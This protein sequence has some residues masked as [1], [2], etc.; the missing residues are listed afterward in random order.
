M[1]QQSNNRFFQTALLLT[2]LALK[3]NI[4]EAQSPQGFKYQGVARNAAS[5][6]I[7]NQNIAIRLSI[8]LDPDGDGDGPLV[9]RERHQTITSDLGVFSLN[10]G[11]GTALSGTFANIVWG[12]NLHAMRTELDP[13]GGNTFTFM[14]S[15]PILSVPYALHAQT[16]ASAPQADPS[17]SNELQ[18]LALNGTQLSISQGNT[19]DLSGIG[20]GGS[21]PWLTNGTN[22]Y[23]DNGSVGIGTN[24]PARHLEIRGTD[25]RFLR[26]LATNPGSSETGI[27]L[28]RGNTAG[29]DWRISNDGGELGFT[30]GSDNFLTEANRHMTLTAVGNLGL[31]TDAPAR[32]F[33][34]REPQTPTLRLHA[35]DGTGTTEAGIEF[36]RGNTAGTDWKMVNDGG[37]LRVKTGADNFATEGETVAEFT[38]NGNLNL[39]G[40]E[41]KNIAAPVAGTDAV[42]RNWVEAQIST[43]A[44]ATLMS[45]NNYAQNQAAMAETDANS[46]TQS[47]VQQYFED[48]VTNSLQNISPV[49]SESMLIP[50][51]ATY[52]RNLVYNGYTDWH[53]PTVVVLV[54]YW[55]YP[56][57]GVLFLWSSSPSCD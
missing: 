48:N 13:A 36:V 38:S 46:Y 37:V 16:A 32:K 34:I 11:Q 27:E 20:G 15:S 42:N 25:D 30:Q 50:D 14:G 51:A 43:Q 1:T 39:Q 12:G 23:Y 44:A 24:A 9:Y 7:A 8:V 53:L 45:A 28:L 49:S 55:Q 41:L 26:I 47:Y 17:P 10:V 5:Q 57:T 4:A 6:P 33:E 31:G 40:N 56:G 22:V 35:F 18:N 54:H 52:C 21:S 19:V 29:T 2:I 3:F